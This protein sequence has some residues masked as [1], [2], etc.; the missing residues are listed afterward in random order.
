MSGDPARFGGYPVGY[1]EGSV[2]ESADVVNGY[3]TSG[4]HPVQP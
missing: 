3:Q 4:A 2:R 1:P